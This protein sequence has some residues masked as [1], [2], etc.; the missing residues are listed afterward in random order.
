[1]T[2]I[3]KRRVTLWKTGIAEGI[4]PPEFLGSVQISSWK[5]NWKLGGY[6]PLAEV[7]LRVRDVEDMQILDGLRNDHNDDYLLQLRTMDYGRRD[8]FD[9]SVMVA[10]LS[11]C[12]IVDKSFE[13]LDSFDGGPLVMV[14]TIKAWIECNWEQVIDYL[15]FKPVKEP[16]GDVIFKA[17]PEAEAESIGPHGGFS[18]TIDE[19][20]QWVQVL[21]RG[22]E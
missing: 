20:V 8:N 1:M 14:M 3:K 18:G 13:E 22:R 10:E 9:G 12:Y 19:L 21:A 4:K 6:K 2:A 7:V 11:K 16:E 17:K 5:W 15:A